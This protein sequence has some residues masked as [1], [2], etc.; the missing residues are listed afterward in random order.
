VAGDVLGVGVLVQ[1]LGV[2][3]DDL[4][5]VDVEVDDDLGA[6][7]LDQADRGLEA[8]VGGGVADQP[9]VL[10]VL[11]ADPDRDVPGHIGG[12]GRPPCLPGCVK[13]SECPL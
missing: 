1:Q 9:G 4:G 3:G 2:G 13:S 11:A 12:Q 8:A 10:H 6:E 7:G 5:G